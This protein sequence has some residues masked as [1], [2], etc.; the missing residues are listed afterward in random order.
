MRMRMHMHI[1]EGTNDS[2]SLTGEREKGVRTPITRQ[3]HTTVVHMLILKCF[4]CS[5]HTPNRITKNTSKTKSIH[6][7]KKAFPPLCFIHFRYAAGVVVNNNNTH[8]MCFALF[9][10]ISSVWFVECVLFFSFASFRPTFIQMSVPFYAYFFSSVFTFSSMCQWESLIFGNFYYI[11]NCCLNGF[12]RVN[13]FHQ[14]ISMD[15]FFFSHF[16]QKSF[17]QK[18]MINYWESFLHYTYILFYLHTIYIEFWLLF[19]ANAW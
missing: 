6:T 9:G 18:N 15:F 17:Q 10:L 16:R 12:P 3:M 8:S 1:V 4:L 14:R 2:L 11:S 5:F 7:S 13:P 19:N